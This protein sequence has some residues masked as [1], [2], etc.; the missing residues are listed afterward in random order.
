M[1]HCLTKSQALL[2]KFWVTAR[3]FQLCSWA[4]RYGCK[5]EDWW[6]A[7]VSSSTKLT[8]L[9][10]DF[11]HHHCSSLNSYLVLPPAIYEFASILS[12]IYSFIILHKWKRKNNSTITQRSRV[13]LLHWY[14]C[15]CG[16]CLLENRSSIISSDHQTP[17][18]GSKL[19]L[20]VIL[21]IQD[22]P[23]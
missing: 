9:C 5:A 15:G 10:H 2:P 21:S 20:N 17:L 3:F 22:L 6:E 18:I 13:F 7:N 8:I 16:L 1:P 12:L 23:M 19:F 4:R 11:I 14:F